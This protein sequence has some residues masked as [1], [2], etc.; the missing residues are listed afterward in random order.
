VKK[1][2]GK[3]EKHEV[4]IDSRKQSFDREL[5]LVTGKL[6]TLSAQTEDRLVLM[7][8]ESVVWRSDPDRKTA[9]KAPKKA[10]RKKSLGVGRPEKTALKTSVD[11][12]QAMREMKAQRTRSLVQ[13]KK[14]AAQKKSPASAKSRAKAFSVTRHP[15]PLSKRKQA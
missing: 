12:L 14:K 1:N 2:T 11:D 10:P 13:S 5:R 8:G 4:V 3:L 15:E 7:R 9:K 6:A